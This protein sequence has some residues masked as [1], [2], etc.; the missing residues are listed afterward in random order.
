MK[1]SRAWL[2]EFLCLGR[3]RVEEH[4][5][6][7]A[8]RLQEDSVLSALEILDREPGVLLADEVGMG[9]TYQAL[10][11]IAAGLK[12]NPKG[13]V[14]VVTPRGV[15]NQQ[16]FRVAGRFRDQ[17]FAKFPPNAFREVT[18]LS[19]LVGA[20]ASHPVVF[21]PVTIFHSTRAQAERGAILRLWFRH[22]RLAGPTRQAIRRRLDGCDFKV[23][24]SDTFLGQPV[25]RMEPD[26]S[27]FVRSSPEDQEGLGDLLDSGGLAAFEQKWRVSRAVDRARFRLIRS[28]LPTL[29]LLVVDE[30]HKLK[31]PWSVQARAVSQVLGGVFSKAVFLTATPFQLG[32]SE[33]RQVFELFGRANVVRPGF[34]EDVDDLFDGIAEY[35][36]TY[37][38]F[39]QDWRLLDGTQVAAMARW[40]R[41]VQDESGPELD[42]IEDLN[43]RRVAQQAWALRELKNSRVEPGF[44]R[45]AIRNLK[46]RKKERRSSTTL[47]LEPRRDEVLPL[48]LY[49]RLLAERS[50]LGR[51][52]HIAA[53]ETNISSSF[54]AALAGSVLSEAAPEATT[55][56][57]QRLTRRVLN[58]GAARHSK[59]EEV[60]GRVLRAGLADEKSLIFC[61]RNATVARVR[62]LLETG[63]MGHLLN[64]WQKLLPDAG[65]EDIFG[66]RDGD[67]R[68]RGE[69]EKLA[70][71]FRRGQD[72]LCLALVEC[73]PWTLF[74]GDDQN[75]LPGALWRAKPTLLRDTNRIL[76]SVRA[77]GIAARR[78]DYRI[79]SRAIDQAVARWMRAHEP[80]R[81]ERAGRAGQ[82][83]VDSD[84]IYVGLDGSEDDEE[85]DI[86]GA[87]NKALEWEVS[88]GALD[89]VLSPRK[90]GIWFP[91][92]T[93]LATYPFDRRQTIVEAVRHYLTRRDLPFLVELLGRAGGS[94]ASG[95]HIRRELER[96]WKAKTNRWRDQVAALF[97]Y[98]PRLGHEEQEQVLEDALRTGRFVQSTID[99]R[100]RSR[101]QN[102]FNTPFFPMVVVGNQT[103]QEG[104]DLHRHCRRVIHH[105]LRW[106]P[107]DLEQRTGR[108]D[109][110]GSLSERLE[111]EDG[112]SEWK[113]LERYLL[114]MRTNDEHQYKVV[115]EREKWLEFLLGRPPSVGDYDL[116]DDPVEPLPEALAADLR[117]RLEPRRWT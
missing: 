36:G 96:W 53:A 64:E 71:R 107:A 56:E 48:L 91:F 94:G 1:R 44:R 92:R 39:E 28:L 106:N 29:D 76:S 89:R 21:A 103:M 114:L 72:T 81:F 73:L 80:E 22:A 42:G 38:G 75:R 27:A 84:Y 35:Q 55:Q 26:P 115:K 112:G 4:I 100:A 5:A 60:T 33:L 40:Y 32:V 117:V 24:E 86:F 109:R 34:H 83:L 95:S 78:L 52:T 9:K 70:A 49:Q 67:H 37:D 82:V 2:R 59:I 13:R 46:P 58:G 90:P 97:D 65:H 108:V 85:R 101:I 57:Y 93:Q 43:V 8:I 50:R 15:L 3:R 10:G 74:V 19:H 116:D 30:A 23:W 7:A 98:L 105:D 102:A 77:S 45:W 16:W 113:I 47:R 41:R 12:Q 68:V 6:E 25:D 88:R 79:A 54:A 20:C 66:A 111:A 17:G 51:R 99:G 69:F 61:E 104:L 18:H 63:W 110:H 62:D 87:R 11:L 31:N 14:L